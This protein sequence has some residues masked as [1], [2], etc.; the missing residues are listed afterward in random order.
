MATDARIDPVAAPPPDA[1]APDDAAPRSLVAINRIARIATQD[2]ALRPMLQRIVDALQ[3]HFGWEF[4]ACARVDREAGVFVCEAVYSDAPTDIV[5]GYSRPLGSGVVG[6]VALEGRTIELDDV[7]GAANFID[8]LQGTRAELCVPVVHEGEVLAVLNAESRRAGAFRGQRVLLETVADQ[9]AGAINAARMHAELQRRADLFAMTSELSRTAL[10]AGSFEQ[11]LDYIT[12][13]IHERF[14]LE[15]CGIFLA[16]H[17]G[18]LALRARTGPPT[19]VSERGSLP[20]G[21]SITL[22]AFRTGEAQFVPDVRLDPD[23]FPGSDR[24]RA[25]FALPIRL[26][27]RLLGVITTQSATVESFTADNRRMLEALGAQVAGAIHLVGAARRLGEVN[28]MLEDRSLE[29]QSAN[30]QLRTANIA[31][32]RLSQRDGLTGIANRRRF[33]ARLQSLWRMQSGAAEPLAVLLVDIDHFKAYNDGYGHLAGD[34]CLRRVANALGSVDDE[35]ARYGGEEFALLLL[36]GDRVEVEAQARRLHAAVAALDLEHRYAPGGRVSVSVGAA[37]LA[38]AA[39]GPAA[40]LL[41]R[42]DEALYEAKRQ[43]RDRVV[44]AG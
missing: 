4:I 6:T 18:R 25:E 37:M 29:L 16:G 2:L 12:A 13:F 3:E 28:R 38:S 22:R 21:P 31:L 15:I 27:G 33:D 23:Y 26:Q 32:E 39:V 8:T 24:V 17:D 9:I 5:P 35:I 7:A 36:S 11:T 41:A 44:M 40:Q 19:R 43:G 10:E 20:D 14:G 30:A 34:D 42:A 1:Q